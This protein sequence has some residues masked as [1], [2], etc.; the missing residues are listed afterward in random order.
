MDDY[1]KIREQSWNRALHSYGT[2]HI[3]RRRADKLRD[4]LRW[5]SFMGIVVPLLVGGV[6][7]SFGTE[8]E[9]IGVVLAVAGI[10]GLAQLALSAWALTSDWQ[11]SYAYAIGS[12]SANRRVSKRFETI[13]ANPPS[14]LAAFQKE[15][16]LLEVEDQ[17]RRDLDNQRGVTSEEERAGMRVALRKFRRECA[18]CGKVP[19]STQPT[20]CPV[21]GDFPKR[22]A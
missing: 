13:A 4:R 16:Q 15:Y 3:F 19:Q 20:S 10:A 5:L 9:H 12:S 1:N 14:D 7:L 18:S 8:F 21:C 6:V 22:L 11:N 17:A 2:G